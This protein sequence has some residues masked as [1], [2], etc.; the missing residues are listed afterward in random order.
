MSLL[1]FALSVH[2]L[3]IAFALGIGFSNIVGFRVAKNLGG[4]KALGI[5]ALRESLIPYSD[6]IFCSDHYQRSNNALGDWRVLQLEVLVPIQNGCRAGVDRDLCSHAAA[7]SQILGN[8]RYVAAWPHPHLCPCCNYGCD[9]G[10]DLCGAH[11]RRL[12]L[13][14]KAR[15]RVKAVP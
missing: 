15:Q 6:I 5:A 11:L 1:Q 12:R 9:I 14:P 13:L 10:C 4:D 3:S 8:P 2:L 7:H